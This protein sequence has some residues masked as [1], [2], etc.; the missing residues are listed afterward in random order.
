[1]SSLHKL[2]GIDFAAHFVQACIEIYEGH[3]ATL[4]S[5]PVVP[6][7]PENSEQ[8]AGSSNQAGK[9]EEPGNG[10]ECTNLIVLI[11]ELY[12]FHVIS[13]G[14]VYDVIRAL[15]APDDFLDGDGVGVELLLKI[16]RS[17]CRFY[18]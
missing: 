15:L 17:E 6:S 9:V 5:S 14:L 7:S 18:M 11:S 10:K 8:G 4:K 1:M 16:T 2:I 3:Y 13:C 12:N